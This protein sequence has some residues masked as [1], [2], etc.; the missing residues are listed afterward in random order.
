MYIDGPRGV[1]SIEDL[2]LL[3]RVRQGLLDL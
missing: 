3:G 1:E 2:E